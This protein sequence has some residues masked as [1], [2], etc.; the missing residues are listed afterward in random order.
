[1]HTWHGHFVLLLPGAPAHAATDVYTTKPPYQLITLLELRV[2]QRLWIIDVVYTPI[3]SHE[4]LQRVCA[5]VE[6]RGTRLGHTRHVIV[7][8][9][10]ARR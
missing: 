7:M 5:G 1:M 4:G 3:G 8:S 10:A 6:S 9:S 2:C